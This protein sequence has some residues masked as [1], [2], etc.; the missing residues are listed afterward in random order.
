MSRSDRVAQAIKREASIIIH[1]GLKDPRLGFVTI[2]R[3][4]LTPDLR[5]AKIFFSVLGREE[6]YKKTK[7]ALASASGFIRSLIAQRINLRFAPEIMFKEDHSAEYSVRI[8]KIL[9]EINSSGLPA[10]GIDTERPVC[11]ASRGALKGREC[12]K[13][14]D[15]PKR[16]RRPH[17]KK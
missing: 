7:K 1:D 8:Q 5:F 15:G 6:D 14:K 10:G 17:K 9:D 11:P 16:E 4:D 12:I 2:T 3:V 13:Q